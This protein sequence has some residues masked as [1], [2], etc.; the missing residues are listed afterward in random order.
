MRCREV[1]HSPFGRITR[2][3]AKR[4]LTGLENRRLELPNARRPRYCGAWL[5]RPGFG[6]IREAG[7]GLRSIHPNV[8]SDKSIEKF[9]CS[10]RPTAPS[11]QAGGLRS[12]RSPLQG[13]RPKAAGWGLPRVA[14]PS[15]CLRQ[16]I[17]AS[18]R[19]PARLAHPS[20]GEAAGRRPATQERRCLKH[21]YLISRI[22]WKENRGSSRGAAGGVMKPGTVVIPVRKPACRTAS[23]A[24]GQMSLGLPLGKTK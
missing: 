23:S 21:P 11:V 17:F 24:A 16:A 14:R 2:P 10:S 6:F 1:V 9:H 4:C 3:D 20:T 8:L 22:V 18:L 7:A 19:L 13:R 5:M 12:S 15:G